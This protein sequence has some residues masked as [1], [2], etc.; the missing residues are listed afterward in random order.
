MPKKSYART[1]K[2][3]RELIFG[4]SLLHTYWYMCKR[5]KCPGNWP[6]RRI[7]R[8]HARH[9]KIMISRGF[10]HNSPLK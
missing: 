2:G 4:H 3:N 1:K 9:V 5:G 6:R 8:D 7:I 10:K